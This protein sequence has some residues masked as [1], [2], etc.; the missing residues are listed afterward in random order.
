[1]MQNTA[2]NLLN[3][4][5][6]APTMIPVISSAFMRAIRAVPEYGPLLL[7]EDKPDMSKPQ[8]CVKG[9]TGHHYI[10]NRSNN[11]TIADVIDTVVALN[12]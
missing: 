10:M 1:M 8:P 5:V 3:V 9:G 11:F 4:R 6:R 12:A 7:R 2:N